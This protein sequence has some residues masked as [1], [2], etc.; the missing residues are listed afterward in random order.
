MN[1][2]YLGNI[3]ICTAYGKADTFE[4]KRKLKTG[5]SKD[6]EL[7]LGDNPVIWAAGDTT[8]INI[9]HKDKGNGTLVLSD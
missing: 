6:K 3:A 2:L 8:D 9:I 5:D 7:T 4:F 1:R